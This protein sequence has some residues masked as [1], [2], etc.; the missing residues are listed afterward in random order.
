MCAIVSQHSHLVLHDCLMADLKNEQY[1][2]STGWSVKGM[3]P[4]LLHREGGLLTSHTGFCGDPN[5]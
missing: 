2:G 5:A 4:Q 3:M 1:R